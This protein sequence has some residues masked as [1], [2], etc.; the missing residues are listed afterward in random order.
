M[1]SWL[2]ENADKNVGEHSL[3]VSANLGSFVCGKKYIY[4]YFVNLIIYNFKQWKYII[5]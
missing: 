2:R 5:K 4:I 3:E 1:K